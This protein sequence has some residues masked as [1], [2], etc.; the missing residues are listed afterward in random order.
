MWLSYPTRRISDGLPGRIEYCD[1]RANDRS[2]RV[3]LSR[4]DLD[5]KVLCRC[6]LYQ[7]PSFVGNFSNTF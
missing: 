2:L 4:T 3:V 6:M 5:K 1:R 7:N